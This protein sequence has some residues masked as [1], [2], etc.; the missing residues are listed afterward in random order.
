MIKTSELRTPFKVIHV[1]A[2]SDLGMGFP[3]WTYLHDEILSRDVAERPEANEG[4]YGVNFGSWLAFAI[5]CQWISQLDF[6]INRNWHD[7]I[8]RFLL[9][10]ASYE[11]ISVKA[12]LGVLPYGNYKLAIELMHIPSLIDSSENAVMRARTKRGEPT[13]PFNILTIENL[14]VRYSNTK[15][16][17]IFLS[18]SPGYVPISA[19]P[20]LELIG[21]YVKNK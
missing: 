1:D 11:A 18:H 19:D 10:D 14:G 9:S 13:I 15:W 16:D 2:H 3:S 12:P 5:G 17:Y 6:V 21:G 8:P 4:P 20:L 7:D